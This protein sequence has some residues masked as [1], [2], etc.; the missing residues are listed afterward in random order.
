M[1][2]HKI[3]HVELSA[4]DLRTTGAFYAELFGWKIEHMPEMDYTTFE[5]EGG[6]GGGFNKVNDRSI[7]PGDIIVYV[8][9]DDIEA[10]L[11]RAEALG[12]RTLIPKTEIPGIGWFGIFKDPVGNR[13]G[14]FAEA[15]PA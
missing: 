7:M 9:S 15:Q 4:N 5:V 6:V 13:I 14:L 3:V 11:R 1:S 2:E 8:D 12:S 10:D